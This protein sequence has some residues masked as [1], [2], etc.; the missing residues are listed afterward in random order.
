MEEGQKENPTNVMVP[1]RENIK[2]AGMDI[3]LIQVQPQQEK[4]ANQLI[5]NN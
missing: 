3:S 5:V 4:P 1:E 2:A